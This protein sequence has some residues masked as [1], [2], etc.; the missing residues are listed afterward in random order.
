[1]VDLRAA[2]FDEISGVKMPTLMRPPMSPLGHLIKTSIDRSLGLLALI[3]LLPLFVAVAL[4]IRLDTPGPV[5]FR[6][7]RT[8]LFGKPFTIFKFR[9]L[10]DGQADPDATTLVSRGDSRVTKVGR[11]LRYFSLDE[12]PQLLNVV[13]GEMSLVGPRPHPAHAKADGKLYNS[14][15]PDYSLRYRVKPGMTGWAQVNGWRGETDTV[16]KLSKRVEFDFRYIESWS[17]WLDF[18]IMILTIPAVLMPKN[19]A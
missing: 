6:Q 8:G 7:V 10:H 2:A 16:E 15:I 18:W 19:N 12:M 11:W 13:R 1:M 3:V 5:F 4:A 14:V 17:L 9:T